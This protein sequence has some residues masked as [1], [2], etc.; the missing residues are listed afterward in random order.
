MQ[1]TS[2]NAG[3]TQKRATSKRRRCADVLLLQRNWQRRLRLALKQE[4]LAASS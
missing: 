1:G 3:G 4:Q 2:S